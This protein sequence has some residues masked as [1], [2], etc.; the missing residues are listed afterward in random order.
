MATE[1][2]RKI[3]VHDS[4]KHNVN[5]KEEAPRLNFTRARRGSARLQSRDDAGLA[6]ILITAF[7]RKFHSMNI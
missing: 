4:V 7:E 3:N 2:E 1:G 5:I 6:G